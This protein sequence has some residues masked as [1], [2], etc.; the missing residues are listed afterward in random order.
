VV[1]N[2]QLVLALENKVANDAYQKAKEIMAKKNQDITEKD[3][4]FLRDAYLWFLQNKELVKSDE[5]QGRMLQ[6]NEVILK[7]VPDIFRKHASRLTHSDIETLE[8]AYRAAARWDLVE[9]K[10]EIGTFLEKLLHSHSL[11]DYKD[12]ELSNHAKHFLRSNIDRR[13]EQ[14][15]LDVFDKIRTNYAHLGKFMA[16][17][18]SVQDYRSYGFGYNGTAYRILFKKQGDHFYVLF[19][20]THETYNAFFNP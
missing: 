2:E 9:I 4:V 19:L 1:A 5:I 3:Q 18:K 10:T 12:F 17:P 7:R 14:V 16:Y 8:R 6:A 11:S 13:L 15:I 20:N